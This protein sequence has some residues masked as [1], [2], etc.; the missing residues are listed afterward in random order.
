MDGKRIIHVSRLLHH[1]APPVWPA[2]G[3]TCGFGIS[4]VH[5]YGIDTRTVGCKP[6]CAYVKCCHEV[7]GVLLIS[8]QCCPAGLATKMLFPS[9]RLPALNT[10]CYCTPKQA[11]SSAGRNGKILRQQARY[12]CLPSCMTVWIPSNVLVRT[13]ARAVNCNWFLEC[14]AISLSRFT[15]SSP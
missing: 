15:R 11:E 2:Q 10:R 13:C 8:N 6:R 3:R 5:G 7:H 1:A 4:Q 9:G 12:A 14:L